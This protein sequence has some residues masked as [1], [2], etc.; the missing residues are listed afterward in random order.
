MT[1]AAPDAAN[2]W[3]KVDVSSAG[4]EVTL[5]ISGRL[6]AQTVPR[7]WDESLSAVGRV[8]AAGATVDA[9]GVTYCDGAGLGLFA[10]IRRVA[11]GKV[12][13]TGLSDALSDMLAMSSLPDRKAPQL[14]P[15]Q[16]AGSV[17]QI[18]QATASIFNELIEAVAFLG[19]LTVALAWALAHPRGVR[20]RDLWRVAT[21]A[22]ADAVPV[23]S[24]LGFLIGLILAFQSAVPLQRLGA[25]DVIPLIVS[26][27]IVRELGPLITAV[28]LAGRSGSA[29][30]AE[31]GT[32]KITEEV[33]A[34]KVLGLAPVRFL[35]VPRVLAAMLV[36]PLLTLYCIV[37]G[38]LGGYVVMSGMNF[39]FIGYVNSVRESLRMSD[40]VGGVAK[41]I[42]F[43]FL[44]GGIGCFRGLRTLTGPGAVGDSTT[45]AVVAGIVLVIIA[46][47]VFGVVY[48]Y[49][50]I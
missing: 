5:A 47:G 15:E 22:G 31:I 20:W 11:P 9:S 40:L 10:E 6:D 17:E 14:V 42:V 36:T 35:V 16:Q 25:T 8:D 23:L 41:T 44:V 39:T 50:G 28:L 29:F 49:L 27:A 45:K 24:L 19:E 7:I 38:I 1:P 21:K 2:S 37:L 12:T 4:A 30:A 48:Y 43:A 18:G 34:L 46:D 13:F 33:N 26:F 3:A 32:M